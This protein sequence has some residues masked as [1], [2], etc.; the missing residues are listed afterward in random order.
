VNAQ[1]PWVQLCVECGYCWPI[2]CMPLTT[3]VAYGLSWYDVLSPPNVDELS[4]SQD[5][6]MCLWNMQRTGRW[7][8]STNNWQSHVQW[9]GSKPGNSNRLVYQEIT[10]WDLSRFNFASETSSTLTLNLHGMKLVCKIF[11]CQLTKFCG[12][13]Q[14][15]FNISKLSFDICVLT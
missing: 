4:L 2:G 11:L 10:N 15:K 3:E 7:S 13:S 5:G 8:M 9:V 14:A 12:F 1:G 6:F